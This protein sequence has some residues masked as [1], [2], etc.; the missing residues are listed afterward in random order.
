MDY[1]KMGGSAADW[2]TYMKYV[3]SVRNALPDEVYDFVQAPWHYDFSYHRCPHDAWL[4]EI[5]GV[6]GSESGITPDDRR[7]GR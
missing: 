4:E 7:I 6:A 1:L 5:V 3:E 2:A